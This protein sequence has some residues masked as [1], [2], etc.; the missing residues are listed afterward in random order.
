MWFEVLDLGSCRGEYHWVKQKDSGWWLV[1]LRFIAFCHETLVP[2]QLNQEGRFYFCAGFNKTFILVA[3]SNEHYHL[4]LAVFRIANLIVSYTQITVKRIKFPVLGNTQLISRKWRVFNRCSLGKKTLNIQF[5]L[6]IMLVTHH[7]FYFH[8][9]YLSHC[10]P[11]KQSDSTRTEIA[12]QE[13]WCHLARA[14]GHP[15]RVLGVSII[16]RTW[17]FDRSP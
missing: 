13:F 4:W 12:S 14:F 1:I 16:A 2:Q 11:L 9:R 3:S 6:A 7:R 17:I 15:S 10:R 5:S 8:R